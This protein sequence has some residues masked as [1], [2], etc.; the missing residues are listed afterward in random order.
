[1]QIEIASCSNQG[2]REYNEDSVRYL[3]RDGVCAVVV[4][5]GLGGHGGGQIA[6]AIAAECIT[7]TFLEDPII[8]SDYIKQL[9]EKANSRVIDEQSAALKMKSTGVALLID[10]GTAIWGHVGDSRLYH[11]TDG[12]LVS[13]T[14]DHS[15]SQVAVFSGEITLD[16]IRHH[17]DRNR[18]LRAFGGEDHI[19]PEISQPHSLESGFH[20]FLLCT[21]GFWEYVLETEMELDLADSDTPYDWLQAMVQRIENL[22]LSDNDNYSAAAVFAGDCES[23]KNN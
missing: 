14:F 13:Q 19:K 5:D 1:M 18:V 3:E 10:D 6:S 23:R 21:D 4:S 20:A 9:F 15:V 8:D 7:Q 22:S 12:H 16:Q 11:F 2:G 17:D